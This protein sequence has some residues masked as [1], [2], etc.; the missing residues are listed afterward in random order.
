[1]EIITKCTLDNPKERMSMLEVVTRLG[2]LLG[3]TPPDI[4][5]FAR[6]KKKR[7]ITKSSEFITL[8]SNDFL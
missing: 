6:K 4:T 8:S 7:A 1:M 5:D 2:E 3:L